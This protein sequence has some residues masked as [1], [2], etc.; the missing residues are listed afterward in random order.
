MTL[1]IS[2][3][4]HQKSKR[5]H[6]EETEKHRKDTRLDAGQLWHKQ[7]TISWCRQRITPGGSELLTRRLWGG[8][9]VAS[10][11]TL[12]CRRRVGGSRGVDGGYTGSSCS[13]A[14][15]PPAVRDPSY[16]ETSGSNGPAQRVPPGE[17]RDTDSGSSLRAGSAKLQILSESL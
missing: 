16:Q 5:Y 11:S 15:R 6:S 14:A 2:S 17:R 1:Y 4:Q 12:W 13:S 9:E 10:L 8:S 3:I 7:D